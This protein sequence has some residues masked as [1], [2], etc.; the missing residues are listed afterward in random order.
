M[1]TKSKNFIIPLVVY[2]FDVMV[3][4]NESNDSLKKN[5]LKYY[6]SIEDVD[7]HFDQYGEDEHLGYTIMLPNGQ[8]IIKIKKYPVTNEDYA[9]VVH[10]IFHAVSLIFHR[11]GIKLTKES[12]EP[13]AYMIEYLTKEIYNKI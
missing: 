8:V 12:D 11:I 7:Y 9:I 6:K 4:L 1:K 13:W 3:S 2:P 10:E 5:L